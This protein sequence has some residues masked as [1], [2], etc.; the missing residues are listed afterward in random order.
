MEMTHYA[1][2]ADRS[3]S[4]D[5]TEGMVDQIH[6]RSLVFAGLL[7]IALWIPLFKLGDALLTSLF[8]T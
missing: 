8:L 2:V 4:L 7:S 1:P 3:G 6:V 5:E